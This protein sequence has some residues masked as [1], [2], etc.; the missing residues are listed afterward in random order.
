MKMV[1]IKLVFVIFVIFASIYYLIPTLRSFIN[2]QYQKTNAWVEDY[3]PEKAVKLGLDLQGGIHLVLGVDTDRA[4]EG[5][6]EKYSEVL[7][8]YLKDE[9]IPVTKVEK[10]ADKN[11][12][13]ILL[14][15]QNDRDK[16]LT[17]VRDKFSIFHYN[18]V[19]SGKFGDDALVLSPDSSWEKQI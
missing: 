2:P 13:S 9:K 1:T 17:F 18:T 16:L 4:F 15:N 5:E 3:I 12:I 7:S 8:T 14:Q 19:E 6:I 10:P 11:V